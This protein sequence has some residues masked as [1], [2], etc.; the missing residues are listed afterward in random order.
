MSPVYTAARPGTVTLCLSRAPSA[1]MSSMAAALARQRAR[2]ARPYA[3]GSGR[4]TSQEESPTGLRLRPSRH[5]T[6]QPR[7]T[8]REP[9][10]CACKQDRHREPARP[11]TVNVRCEVR[12]CLD[13]DPR[14]DLRSGPGAIRGDARPRGRRPGGALCQSSRSFGIAPGVHHSDSTSAARSRLAESSL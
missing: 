1:S 9:S 4:G 7:T 11:G 8:P 13:R 5:A 3:G 2:A 10:T 12:H 6:P 14:L